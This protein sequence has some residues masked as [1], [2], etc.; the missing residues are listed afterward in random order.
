[1]PLETAVVPLTSR[2]SFWEAF[3]FWAR[4]G[5][6]SFG[7]PAGQIALLHQELVDRRRWIEQS[8]FLH[9]VNFCM[10]LPGPEAQQLAIYCGWFLHGIPG[11]IL[12]GSLFVLPSLLMLSGLGWVYLMIRKSA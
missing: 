3:R 2:P 4:M 11:G 9:A 8:R 5:C 6:I 1:M 7:G 12:A 10:A